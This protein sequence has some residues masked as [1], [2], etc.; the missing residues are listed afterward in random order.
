MHVVAAPDKFRGTA[1][2][3]EVADAVVRG[4]RAAGGTGTALPM[5]DGGEGTLAVLGGANRRSTV[6][7]PLGEPVEAGWRLEGT[8][9]V[10]EMAAASGLLLA[11]GAEENQPLDATTAG[12]CLLYTSPSPRDS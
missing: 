1:S 2:A 4:A 5:A 12:T 8:T 6:T 11:G 9:A 10:I 3:A 7:G